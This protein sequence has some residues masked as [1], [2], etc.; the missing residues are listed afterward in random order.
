MQ[1]LWWEGL[2]TC[3]RSQVWRLACV[4]TSNLD[5]KTVE[6]IIKNAT[7][8]IRRYDEGLYD[9]IGNSPFNNNPALNNPSL[10]NSG[11]KTLITE[12]KADENQCF[13]RNSKNNVS[14]NIISENNN[15]SQNI[16]FSNFKT[17]LENFNNK[18]DFSE[19]EIHFKQTIS[20]VDID[21][22]RT[23]PQLNIFQTVRDYL[24]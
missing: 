15:N 11:S 24:K 3:I 5:T 13:G 10:N 14:E 19:D 2:P 9:K 8:H 22:N 1:N 4:N 20:S 18:I 23:F 12:I 21:I 6:R 16:Q 7:E 17:E